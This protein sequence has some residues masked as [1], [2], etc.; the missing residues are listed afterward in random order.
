[1]ESTQTSSPLPTLSGLPHDIKL[2]IVSLVRDQRPTKK[3]L[4]KS[5]GQYSHAM[6]SLA[7]VN[8]EMW[9]LATDQIYK[10]SIIIII[11]II[12]IVVQ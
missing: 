6:L 12:I 11:I 5:K 7:L 1:M 9:K 10:V 3:V 8:K 4:G 2:Q